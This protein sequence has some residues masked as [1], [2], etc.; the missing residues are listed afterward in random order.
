MPDWVSERGL[1]LAIEYIRKQSGH[2][3]PPGDKNGSRSR[4]NDS[5]ER[6]RGWNGNRPA[7]R[8]GK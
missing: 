1:R 8:G 3:Q 7:R 4:G 2:T 5:L 6:Q